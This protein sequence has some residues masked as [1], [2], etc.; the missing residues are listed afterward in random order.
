MISQQKLPIILTIHLKKLAKLEIEKYAVQISELLQVKYNRITVKDTSTRWGSCS[1]D[2]NLSFSWR[3]ALA[4]RDVMEY[5]VVHELCH[6]IEMNHS[7]KFWKLVYKICPD[8]FV[9]KTWLKKHGKDL[10]HFF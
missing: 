4:P 9:A 6:L 10:H 3:L 2:K 1:I 7:P 5:V 8:Y